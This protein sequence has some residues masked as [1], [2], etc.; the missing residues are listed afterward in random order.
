M[1]KLPL[2]ALCA[3][4]LPAA[5]LPGPSTA[6]FAKGVQ[7]TV[8]GYTGASALSGFPVLVRIAEDSPSG[9][10]YADMES[11]NAAD[12]NDIDLAFVDMDGSGLP[13]EID[14]WDPA[15]TSLIWVKLPSMQNGTEFVMC[16]GSETSGKTVCGD[17]PFAGYY[18][19]WHM[20]EANA[21]DSSANHLDGTANGSVTVVDAKLGSGTSFPS[22]AKIATTNT[23]NS[24]FSSAISFETWARSSDVSGEQALFGKEALATFKFKGGVTWFTTPGKQDFDKIN[25]TIAANTWYHIVL[26]FVPNQAAKVYVDGNLVKTQS[27][28]KGYNDLAKSCPVV[29]GSNQW[30]Q[31]YKGVLDECR[32]LTTELSADWI[33]ADYATQNDAS[34]LTSGSAQDLGTPGRAATV[35]FF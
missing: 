20:T 24:A 4:A 23:L 14:T 27:D 31:Y 13:F 12:K 26:T 8:S 15:G 2:F 29:F 21:K 19:V 25:Q 3:L 32:L 18:G 5:A 17:N 9:F 28:S 35:F 30:N 33:A 34:F 16:W 11:A 10:S 1:K 7:F 6:S 22:N